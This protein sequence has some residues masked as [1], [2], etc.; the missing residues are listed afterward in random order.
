MIPL[1]FAQ[2]RLWFI[3]RFDGPSATYNLPFLLRLTGPLDVAALTLAVRDVVARHESLRTVLVEDESGVPEQKVLP[4]DPSLPTVPVVDVQPQDV[5]AVVAEAA[6]YRFTLSR[7]APVRAFL[8]RSGPEQH[9]LVLV[10]HHIAADGESMAPLG[11]DL[12]AAYTAR[13]RSTA[14]E[15]PELAVQYTDYTLWQRELLGDDQDPGSVLATQLRH[16]R[17]E[18]AGAPAQLP[19]PTDRPRPSS[20]SHRGD[21]VEFV[22][23]GDLLTEV[24]EL[25][26]SRGATAAMAMQ[27]AL[28]ALLCLLGGGMDIP[29][30]STIAG[31]GEEGLADLVGFFVNTWVLR[32]DLSGNPS[33]ETLIDRVRDKALG[34]Y[35][36]QD[37]PFE[38]L[39]E[40]LNPERSRAYHP[41]FQVMFTWQ[42][43][44][45]LDLDMP[46]VAARLEPVWTRTA[47]FDLEFNFSPD[48]GDGLR[49]SLE[50]ATD[51]F[52]RGTVADICAR[53]LHVLRGF[54]ADPGASV[55]VI[56]VLTPAERI[57]LAG[58]NDTAAPTPDLTAA[59]VVERQVAVTPEAVAVECAGTSLTYRELNARAN[60]LAHALV[61]HG[62]GPEALIGLALPR[63][64]DLVVALLGILKAGA[65]Y[66]PIDPRYPSRRLD[67]I[68][69]DARPQFVLIDAEA[70]P[71]LPNDIPVLLL[72]DVDLTGADPGA[73][74]GG[75]GPDNLAYVMYT[76][77][78]T[79]TPKGVGITHRGV[80]NGITR[81]AAAVPVRPRAKVLAGASVN[82]DV[83][84]FEIVT[85]LSVG[86]TVEVVRDVL[87]L[88]ERD[89]WSGGVIHSV[90]SVFAE[91]VDQ[92]AGRTA[93]DVLVFAGEALP[94]ALVTR[95]RDAFPGVRV[96]N[97][98]GQS[99]SFYATAFAVPDTAT[100]D[101]DAS[102]PIGTPLGNMRTYVLGPGLRPVPPGV[103]GELYVAGEVGRGYHGRAGMTA[104]RFVADPLGPAGS[105]MYR[106]GDLARWTADGQLQYV[107]RD[108]QQLKIRGQRIE[109]AEVEAVLT[110]HPG[111]AQA[112]VAARPGPGGTRLVG[113]VLPS[114]AARIGTV[115]SLGELD[116][117]LT[118]GVSAAELRT[119]AAERLPEFMVP[120]AFVMLN[121]LP[122]APNGKLDR[123]A[124]P[125]PE[126]RNA[127]YRAPLT[128]EEQVLADVYAE[129]LGLHE[130]GVDDDFFAVGGDSIRSIQVVARARA[131]GVEVTPREIFQCRTVAELAAVV[132]GRADT[133]PAPE[134]EGSGVG[135]MPLLPVA[136][137]LTELGGGI[138]RFS[139]SMV[140][141]LPDGIDEDGLVATIGAV[142]DRHDI[143]RS[144]LESNGLRADPPG[145]VDV[146][147]LI[148]RIPL[149]GNWEELAAVELDAATGRLDP[150]AG[151]MAQFVWFDPGRLLVVLHHFVVDG[152]SWRILLP[153]FAQAWE[154][155]RAGRTPVLPDVL[156]SA[157]RWTDALMD[158]SKERV[159]ELPFWRSVLD[160]PDPLLGLREL[161]PT[162]DVTS[163]VEHLWVRLPASVTDVLLTRVPA[164]F[165]SGVNDGLLAAL[166]LAVTRWRRVRGESEPSV[167]VRM[168]GHG[169]EEGIVPGAD[170]SR[171]V[172]WF[173]SMFPVRLRTTLTDLDEAF[174]GGP[175]AGRLVK[176]VK[177]QLLAVPDK[178]IGYG[179]LR[180][181]NDD[182]AAILGGYPTG[183]I[184]FNYL[185]R[186][187]ATDMPTELRGLGWTETPG[188]SELVARPDEDMPALS[189]LDVNA[190]V[191]DTEQGPQLEA[192]L[193]F[194]TGV[195]AREEV[196]EI[197]D[198]WCAALAGLARHAV[199]PDAG[200]LTPSDVTL[201]SVGQ[202]E[203][204]AWEKRYPRVVDVWPLTALQSG[205]LF[206][207][208]LADAKFD[209][210]HMQL[211][212]HLS[213]TVD[214]ARMRAAGQAILD[215][216]ANLRVA[217][218]ANAAGDHVQVVP[219]RAALPWRHLD[220]SDQGPE[221]VDRFLVDDRN[222]H[223]DL[224]SPPL[225]RMSL[226]TCGPERSEL[227]VTAHHVL[228]DG[229]SVPLLMRDLLQ[230][231][232]SSGDAAALPRAR[233]YRD[234]LGWLA[235]QDRDAATRAWLSELDGIDE[236]TL[237][238]GGSE[239]GSDSG[240]IGQ[241]DVPL[242]A[243]TAEGLARRAAELGVTVNTVVQG[244][245]ALVLGGLTG[246]Q[247][248]VFGATVSG[249]PADLSDVDSMVGL[250]VNTVPVRVRCAPEQSIGGLLRELQDRQAALLDHHHV[251]LT[252]IHRAT[253]LT[254]LFDTVVVFESFPVDHVGISTANTA[255]GVAITGLTPYSG[256]HYPL[257]VTADADPNPRIALQYQHDVF[258][259]EFVLEIADRLC[260]V[261]EQFVADPD[262]RVAQVDVLAVAERE[263]AV[264][265]WNA[266]AHAVPPATLHAAFE[267]QV[268]LGAG[269][270]ALIFDAETLTYG[271]FNAR[272]NRFAHWLIDRGVGPGAVVGV[273]LPRSFDLLVAIYGVV[274]AGAAF[275]PMEVDL[276]PERVA[277]MVE[278]AS[279]ALVIESVPDVSAH[280][281]E[282]PAVPM[283]ADHAAYIIYTSGSTGRPKGVAVPHRSIMNR[284]RWGQGRYGM[285]G[286]D[287]MLLK[288][289]VGFDVSVPELFWPLQVGAALVIARPDGHKDP[290]Y[291]ARL[292][293][294]RDITDV[295]FAPSTLATFLAE[296]SAAECRT[297]RR[298]EA[299]GEALSTEL[300]QRCATVLPQVELHN[301]YG[302][303]EAAVE[304]TAWQYQP[305]LDAT[306]AGVPIG[307]PVWNTQVYVLDAALRPVPPG[308]RGELYLAGVQLAWGYVRR[309]GLTAERFVANP[310]TPGER[311]Y[312][313]GDVVAWRQ[314]G[315]LTY[316]GRVDFQ[317]K[318]R[319][320]RIEPGEIETM[321][322]AHP[323]VTQA[324]VIA[325]ED[326]PGDQRLVAYVVPDVD[327]SDGGADEQV[328]EWK[329]VYDQ[330]YADATPAAWGE[331]F[332]GWNSSYTGEPIPTAQMRDWRDA[333]VSHVLRWS[334]RR[335]LELGVGS[336][337][338]L[339]HLVPAVDE[340]W[341]T[342]FSAPVLDE[343]RR[344]VDRAG[345][346][347]RVRLRCQP[348]DDT[349]GL[350]AE[351]FD[352]VVL[353]S[354]AQ[355]FPDARYLDRVLTRA[356][357]VLAPGGR[358][359]IGDV[360][361]LGSL[362]ALRAAVHRAHNPAATPATVRAVV[363]QSL[364]TEKELLL[365]PEWFVRW[366]AQHD[367]VQV[368]VRLKPGRAHN[369]LTRHRYEVV[370]HKAPAARRDLA[371]LP[372]VVWGW[373]A[374]SLDGLAKICRESGP[375]RV[376]R[377]PNA[378]L[379]AELDAATALA[380]DPQ[381]LQDWADGLGWGV[382][383]TWATGSVE[384]FD[385]VVLPD[386]PV[387]GQV[388]TGVFTPSDRAD[389]T[390]VNAPTGA[391]R[392]GSLISGLRG[393]LQQ[394]LPE[395][396]TLSAVV[397]IAE[398]PLTASGKV[399]RRAL[400]VPDYAATSTGRPPRNTGERVLC[401]LMAEVLGL[402]RVGIDDDFFAMGGHS[403]L[404]TRFVSRVRTSLG[405]ELPIRVLFEHPTVAELANAVED[406]ARPARPRVRRMDRSGH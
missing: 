299:A 304:V 163:T 51:L 257:T 21:L 332:T 254:V 37:L 23:P 128:T 315:A 185:G 39:V 146:R 204:D 205:L 199:E 121:R 300:A 232:G 133:S 27:A 376:T 364:L 221:A 401:E 354:V 327:D 404:A 231:Y 200:G 319:G 212:F 322:M 233:G 7:E 275:L 346:S 229:W 18:L 276:P 148:R 252:E 214:P 219:D 306:G 367:D 61:A 178:G 95:V 366:A 169:R 381:D 176:S 10:L 341:G 93:V 89:S 393:Y 31:R 171:T 266:T 29:I 143:L 290:A 76:S 139:M 151:R 156:T 223:F 295:D 343:L 157:R 350:P 48:P 38:R 63:S 225:V 26:R 335:V 33:A 20:A 83:S 209:A 238:A 167:L 283:S 249:R 361:Y 286:S 400:P 303:T 282:D 194:P 217:F 234:F 181:L 82:F 251:G 264:A 316:L 227:V 145:S 308:V 190:L 256:T 94:P 289:S 170:L 85:P 120:A 270:V 374:D 284:I 75:P 80:V 399:D 16:W 188:C 118:A 351:G 177:E 164:V 101:L 356:L 310:F 314:D 198:L 108:D 292:I 3:D 342:D 330:T 349:S 397:P 91:L 187:S 35:D 22:V 288:T 347:D 365:D 142:V 287:R 137:Y 100:S 239:A 396:M 132:A 168:E 237:L 377:M 240:D 136:R 147:T 70:Q 331:D 99:E 60:R 195:L 206:H 124:L 122:L 280:P 65:A 106:T 318:V 193:S 226:V 103:V 262:R 64:A 236:P 325:R 84:V 24:T 244:A 242:T 338:L 328:D 305:E 98:Y 395:Y 5:D 222:A 260:R 207:A 191:T 160:G 25:A 17:D 45:G 259:H 210:Y 144:R 19:L 298:I 380:V 203:L 387:A 105:R 323:H 267:A 9:V 379:A 211:V 247:D 382:A 311:M 224:A 235:R 403:L 165:H 278:D 246:R 281:D 392:I 208:M 69:D 384:H 192:R 130:V 73:P 138:N 141:D 14:P 321:L 216:Y 28:A 162:V 340:Y 159:A 344:Q 71:V 215:R 150:A 78:S 272:A 372:V 11:R 285:S 218:A 297:L 405:V 110:T 112:V 42:T 353:N 307:T 268:R 385:A 291:L 67:Q 114:S 104:E 345:W 183:Q 406:G 175:A 41:L 77:G 179:L 6:D 161:D 293:Q 250:F 88:A 370:L 107:G 197:A 152:V 34:A 87:E 313:T 378:R 368:D 117:D 402:D 57:M 1:S 44:P 56:D 324:T 172:G 127:A 97:A 274:K 12:A 360:R 336:G 375:V 109:V 296:P 74:A 30:G 358:V 258:E 337:L 277:W 52:D 294:E 46:D 261:L 47:K 363:E 383:A 8:L 43:A 92:I 15:W 131:R 386:G 79:G 201:V 182:T 36:N 390:L 180:Y 265:G 389:R 245:W 269:Q 125:D 62:A 54:A 213:G 348:A 301:L 248:V 140:L 241:V 309:S 135:W 115:A 166:A 362:R 398:V 55:N 326:Q 189:T 255:A 220:L 72:D 58:V 102:T 123:A 371:N 155:V 184:A 173:T 355:Y 253:G 158:A 90:P 50:Y 154:Q 13:L 271:E 129:V 333:A 86:G 4:V 357:E 320:F 153:D 149:R 59:G 359:V 263:L 196:Q 317:V 40:A 391:R 113:Y 339:A 96:V 373:Q 279:P 81:L 2:R 329:Q 134:P 394:R 202:S 334:P 126:Y 66:V 111:V 116:L 388:V 53:F 312:R 369:E 230:L 228:F 186:F 352:T 68:L 273:R 119:F 302:P 32:A 243:S 174:A 49:C